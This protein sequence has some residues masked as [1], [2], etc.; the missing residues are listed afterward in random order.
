M[1]SFLS[2]FKQNN[3]VKN[4]LICLP[5]NLSFTGYCHPHVTNTAN[6]QSLHDIQQ[7][8]EGSERQII[9]VEPAPPSAVTQ[10]DVLSDFFTKI[11]IWNSDRKARIDNET[12]ILPFYFSQ[13]LLPLLS[14]AVSKDRS[15]YRVLKG[16]HREI[17]RIGIDNTTFTFQDRHLPTFLDRSGYFH[18]LF[19]NIGISLPLPPGQLLDYNGSQTSPECLVTVSD[20]AD[21]K[22]IYNYLK[23]HHPIPFKMEN[24][25]IIIPFNRKGLQD[26]TIKIILV[27]SPCADEL[28]LDIDNFLE[29]IYNPAPLVTHTSNRWDGVIRFLTSGTKEK[30]W[31]RLIRCYTEGKRTLLE[32][33]ETIANRFFLTPL[34]EDSNG[35]TL[36]TEFLKEFP[37]TIIPD[38]DTLLILALQFAVST[39]LSNEEAEQFF[40]ALYPHLK[41]LTPVTDTTLKS[42]LLCI[43]KSIPFSD[44]QALLELSAL[45][46]AIE[47][48]GKFNSTIIHSAEK[49]CLK[50]QVIGSGH[51]LLLPFNPN[52]ALDTLQRA[53]Y[54]RS[55][56]PEFHDLYAR[57]M[58]PFTGKS[59]ENRQM[60]FIKTH[61]KFLAFQTAL[62]ASYKRD[63]P[64]LSHLSLLTL[65]ETASN[66]SLVN[67]FASILSSPFQTN[68]LQSLQHN[69]S[70]IISQ[71]STSTVQENTEDVKKSA[72]KQLLSDEQP[73]T[74]VLA[75]DMWMESVGETQ[76]VKGDQLEDGYTLLDA[77][78]TQRM[79]T[80]SLKL[81]NL[82]SKKSLPAEERLLLAHFNIYKALGSCPNSTEKS[83]LSHALSVQV[84]NTLTNRKFTRNQ[85]PDLPQKISFPLFEMVLSAIDQE[86]VNL[87]S[88]LFL[89]VV[90]AQ[91]F[92]GDLI[93]IRLLGMNIFAHM[94]ED[95]D[96]T[97]MFSAFFLQFLVENHLWIPESNHERL[98]KLSDLLAKSSYI[99]SIP[100]L[101]FTLQLLECSCLSVSERE[102]CQ[103]LHERLVAKVMEHHLTEQSSSS[104]GGS[105]K[106]TPDPS[107]AFDACMK[108][109]TLRS[110]QSAYILLTD[111]SNLRGWIANPDL[112]TEK[113]LAWLEK[114]QHTHD[115]LNTIVN[116]ICLA[117]NPSMFT[118]SQTNSIV[119]W[120]ILLLNETAHQEKL[121]DP[122]FL[123]YLIKQHYSII[124]KLIDNKQIEFAA[125]FLIALKPFI[126][127]TSWDTQVTHTILSELPES[128]DLYEVVS[129][130][131]DELSE[132]DKTLRAGYLCRLGVH[133]FE[134]EESKEGIRL[135][136]ELV[137]KG[138]A[139]IPPE[140]YQSKIAAYAQHLASHPRQ[141]KL[142]V[143][144]LKLVLNDITKY[145]PSL[146]SSIASVAAKLVEERKWKD[147]TQLLQDVKHGASPD[148]L[149][150]ITTSAIKA[151]SA[152]PHDDEGF[153]F[154]ELMKN[155]E[156]LSYAHIETIIRSIAASKNQFLHREA[157][158]AW[159][160]INQRKQLTPTELAFGWKI[161][162]CYPENTWSQEYIQEMLAFTPSETDPAADEFLRT[163]LRAGIAFYSKKRRGPSKS[164]MRVLISYSDRLASK[165]S[166]ND[167]QRL[168]KLTVK[169]RLPIEAL[170]L[171]HKFKA[172]IG[173][174][175]VGKAL[176]RIAAA[177]QTHSTP[178]PNTASRYLQ[179]LSSSLSV[180]INETFTNES[181][182]AMAKI[183][184]SLAFKAACSLFKRR[185]DVLDSSQYRRSFLSDY[186]QVLQS[187]KQ[188]A[189]SA[190]DYIH[191]H[192][193]V[194]HPFALK[195]T[196]AVPAIEDL[197]LTLLTS[198]SSEEVP[199]S[200]RTAAALNTF[201]LLSKHMDIQNHHFGQCLQL[202]VR[203]NL[204]TLQLTGNNSSFLHFH[205][206]L[207]GLISIPLNRLKVLPKS[208]KIDTVT[209]SALHELQN[210][211]SVYLDFLESKNWK[212]PIS[213]TQ[214]HQRTVSIFN[215]VLDMHNRSVLSGFKPLFKRFAQVSFPENNELE[216][217]H[218]QTVNTLFRSFSVQKKSGSG[219]ASVS[220]M[221]VLNRRNA[222]FIANET[223][224][225]EQKVPVIK[226]AFESLLHHAKEVVITQTRIQELF[227]PLIYSL[228][229]EQPGFKQLLT[230]A[231]ETLHDVVPHIQGSKAE[232][233]F[234]TYLYLFNR[235][236][237]IEAPE[238]MEYGQIAFNVVKKTGELGQPADLSRLLYILSHTIHY[239]N[240][241]QLSAT[242][243]VIT[244]LITTQEIKPATLSYMGSNIRW[245]MKLTSFHSSIEDS[246][247]AEFFTSIFEAFIL[248]A[249]KAKTID[250]AD[251][252]YTL[253][254]SMALHWLV[255]GNSQKL[256]NNVPYS[257]TQ[258]IVKV[259][260]LILESQHF[261]LIEQTL[262]TLQS[263]PSPTLLSKTSIKERADLHFKLFIKASLLDPDKTHQRL[264]GTLNHF[265]KH[266]AVFD[267][268][269]DQV[270]LIRKTF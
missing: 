248:L 120:F 21:L 98:F 244:Q 148:L 24:N 227:D 206:K 133:S 110:F 10:S 167:A 179:E 181:I 175:T 237:V 251:V 86:C 72:I 67:D 242:I 218:L 204:S 28:S 49:E 252:D 38:G 106:S 155:N 201:I 88:D 164:M 123:H 171:C 122:A 147:L 185:L 166:K 180:K 150:T 78:V 200:E 94:I 172:E 162:T 254:I 250:E 81:L 92:D 224:T 220:F 59:L 30:N 34:P 66:R 36:A 194:V 4:P 235:F 17:S 245:L 211:I 223:V 169:A 114:N 142:A 158:Q 82:L 178:I 139:F 234:E 257:L 188:S 195:H 232:F 74:K 52:E 48:S 29:N 108:Q 207:F 96:L 212:N 258:K 53:Y 187:L 2:K 143:A 128:S 62:E 99:D 51:T 77:L 45:R 186:D 18:Q 84:K 61:P 247:K 165:I 9:Q 118:D 154:I 226:S 57:L 115:Q 23:I 174:E 104:A 236:P 39:Q 193:I 264:E 132:H 121:P 101:S 268:H 40:T 13:S 58:L 107:E 41:T 126:K 168:F 73:K 202:A 119:K 91:L 228:S 256:Y 173:Y 192:Q 263:L 125:N 83:A 217:K 177:L 243:D 160:Q 225:E 55:E 42:V 3:I 260:E 12:P 199:C 112:F 85:L 109:G 267:Q 90:N 44:I 25:E 127:N 214:L 79:W 6:P 159:V 43:R 196:R 111:K 157:I 130:L 208:R 270:S 253:F 37:P 8:L 135:A 22:V 153:H 144:V 56:T 11:N 262:V 230:F 129:S 16:I 238:N 87:A 163:A 255:H 246:Q 189:R 213:K 69:T 102:Y 137:S 116:Y 141:V 145:E 146:D 241:E 32:E 131:E 191:L 140:N 183:P 152:T 190:E 117:T 76:Y 70:P 205:E 93:N 47:G 14:E 233:F 5:M 31:L 176:P 60:D 113:S 71:L 151:W 161:M 54:T 63:C 124:R 170:D 222:A 184:N 20:P 149:A 249:E 216:S 15:A 210:I 95:D 68:Y 209:H 103:T 65:A 203:L 239:L 64:M 156:T 80:Q 7:A 231:N 265:L 35:T 97:P 215:D 182:I 27:G 100:L 240:S 105:K 138:N 46:T 229:G 269:Q 50:M 266:T 261:K 26:V 19:Q 219:S 134:K 33:D 1:V 197:C 259:K 198:E 89:L 136:R 75:Y 221:N